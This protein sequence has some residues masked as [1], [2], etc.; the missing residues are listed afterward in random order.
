MRRSGVWWIHSESDPRWRASAHSNAVGMFLRPSEIDT[1]I[2]EL[3]KLYGA[4]SVDL[5]WGYEKD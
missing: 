1:K 2:L 4:P 3:T 5:E